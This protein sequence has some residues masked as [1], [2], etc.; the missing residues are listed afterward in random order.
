[1]SIKRNYRNLNNLVMIFSLLGFLV[2]C[3]IL[4]ALLIIIGDF[5]ELINVLNNGINGDDIRFS[6]PSRPPNPILLFTVLV[7]SFYFIVL[8]PSIFIIR[9]RVRR[10]IR[11]S[12][13]KF[14]QEGNTLTMHLPRS[15]F[16]FL[17]FIRARLE[18]TN[19]TEAGKKVRFV[20][21][22]VSHIYK[23]KCSFDLTDLPSGRYKINGILFTLIDPLTLFDA[24]F[25]LK[26]KIDHSFNIIRNFTVSS[27]KFDSS[28]LSDKEG[29]EV[30]FSK[31]E[32]SLFSIK[33][34]SKGDPLKRI[35][36]K[37]SAKARE[38]YVRVPEERYIEHTHV[39]LLL[40]LYSPLV[41]S[42]DYD[43]IL[44]NYLNIATNLI[45]KISKSP[46][47]KV[48]LHINSEK[49]CLLRNIESYDKHKITNTILNR[50]TFQSN[51]DLI[52]FAGDN[53]YINLVVISLASDATVK[54]MSFN[55][56]YIIKV[57]NQ[58]PSQTNSMVE[59]IFRTDNY[60]YHKPMTLNGVVN[61]LTN[62]KNLKTIRSH[63][64]KIEAIL[65]DN[66]NVTFINAN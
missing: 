55:E 44:G 41:L 56:A 66:S 58:I 50:S 24:R 2:F 39:D 43:E 31:P 32:E 7:S 15:F 51:K 36:W 10:A 46:G 63:S 5:Q 57:S 40:N 12:T 30:I 21:Q 25:Y 4:F 37:N 62:N 34:Y 22:P 16:Q 33:E 9:F 23:D 53:K 47:L 13:V 18:I 45:W 35:H 11:K 26:D 59:S 29:K 19:Q 49:K 8:I 42:T 20:K 6:Y 28:T 3:L 48:N 17:F 1:M 38:F 64:S 61:T 65:Q 52:T 60:R 27:V 14:S 54:D